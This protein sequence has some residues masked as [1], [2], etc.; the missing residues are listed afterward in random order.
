MGKIPTPTKETLDQLSDASL[1]VWDTLLYEMEFSLIF[2]REMTQS[3]IDLSED[4]VEKALL[5]LNRI[6]VQL[7]T[8]N[9]NKFLDF[10][11]N[12]LDKIKNIRGKK[13]IKNL[14]ELLQA[15]HYQEISFEQVN[16]IILEFDYQNWHKKIENFK[17]VR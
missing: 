9:N 5:Y 17:T 12:I 7:G 6:R 16:D 4:G 14:N 3:G 10:F 11:H 13:S 15:I 2:N 1:A 8:E